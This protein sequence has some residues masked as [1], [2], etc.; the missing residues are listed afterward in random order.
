MSS[1]TF[2]FC[3]FTHIHATGPAAQAVNA[4]APRIVIVPDV[5][6]I[7]L[8]QPLNYAPFTRA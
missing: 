3:Q 6:E 8:W 4:Q 1:A 2:G 5:H 7:G